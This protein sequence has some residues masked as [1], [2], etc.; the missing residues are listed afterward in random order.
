[1]PKIDC[2]QYIVAA[3]RTIRPKIKNLKPGTAAG[4]SLY[5]IFAV[6]EGYREHD[7]RLALKELIEAGSIVIIA[8]SGLRGG[9]AKDTTISVIPATAQLSASWWRMT[10]DGICV[11]TV[12]DEV[13]WSRYLTDIRLYVV[14]DGLPQSM[15]SSNAARINKILALAHQEVNK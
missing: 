3:I 4:V 7:F 15:T 8:K 12:A 10:E 5:K 14:V 9:V 2:K 13:K 11:D 6:A 1:M